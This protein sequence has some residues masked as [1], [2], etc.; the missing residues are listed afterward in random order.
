[1]ETI[2]VGTECHYETNCLSSSAIVVGKG[3]AIPV[4]SFLVQALQ[5]DFVIMDLLCLFEV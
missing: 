3:R 1:M 2:L 5:L 4:S